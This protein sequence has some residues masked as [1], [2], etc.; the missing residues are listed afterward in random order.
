M[1]NDQNW[2]RCIK[3]GDLKYGEGRNRSKIASELKA[4]AVAEYCNESSRMKREDRI[5]GES[6]DGVNIANSY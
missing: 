1:D 2:S 3:A 5:F 6:Q 4:D